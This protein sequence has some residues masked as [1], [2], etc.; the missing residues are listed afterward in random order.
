MERL[1]ILIEKCY[2][3]FVKRYDEKKLI[4]G[5][6]GADAVEYLRFLRYTA[7]LFA[8]MTFFGLVVLAPINQTG[9][10]KYVA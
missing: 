3:L 5:Q 6:S 2:L 4:S 7:I 10:V 8:I 9:E 1:G